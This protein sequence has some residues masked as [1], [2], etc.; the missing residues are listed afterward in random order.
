MEKI[1]EIALFDKNMS[2]SVMAMSLKNNGNGES[3]ETFFMLAWSLW[4]HRN[5]RILGNIT[6]HANESMEYALVLCKRFKEVQPIP[7]S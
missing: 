3:L 1:P 2:I 4:Y 7:T 5:K 6:I